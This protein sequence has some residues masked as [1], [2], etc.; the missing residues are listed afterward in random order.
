[1][2]AATGPIPSGSTRIRPA[3]AKA[4]ELRQ[5]AAGAERVP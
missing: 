3:P 4:W 1:M 2:L 5:N